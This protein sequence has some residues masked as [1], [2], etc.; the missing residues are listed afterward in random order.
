MSRKGNC[1]DNAVAESFFK[2]IKIE[3]I[4]R[5]EIDS[6]TMA[7]RLVFDYIQGWYNTMRIHSSLGGLSPLQ[8]FIKKSNYFVVTIKLF[9]MNFNV[10]EL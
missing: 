3:C 1:W 4:Y 9:G 5:Q 8:A 10:M 7:Y 6:N 2:T